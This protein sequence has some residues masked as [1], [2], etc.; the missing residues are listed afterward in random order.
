MRE[1]SL[2]ILDIMENCADGG[3]KK[4]YLCIEEDKSE[5][6]LKIV[7]EDDGR[8]MGQEELNRAL[9]PFYTT[10]STRRVGLGLPLFYETTKRCDGDFRLD[11]HPGKGTRV[12]ASFTLDHID[13]PPMGDL[14]GTIT[15]FMAG[16][17]EV[18][19][20]YVHRTNGDEFVLDTEEVKGI[21]GVDE[22][23]DPAIIEFLRGKIR[24]A[25]GDLS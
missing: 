13:L 22:L 8:G 7:I 21:L 18:D 24:E 10:R 5:G 4:V 23:T 2:H 11:S 1:L 16:H 6:K 20:T 17:P 14:A 15:A 25:V 12:E 3:A 9:D 19:L